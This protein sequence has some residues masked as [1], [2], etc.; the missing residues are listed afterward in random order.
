MIKNWTQKLLRY[1]QRKKEFYGT[2]WDLNYKLKKKPR[3]VSGI[4]NLGKWRIEYIDGYTLALMW[5]LQFLKK[6]NDFYTSKP[7]PY[8]LDCGSNIG[9]SVLRYKELYPECKITAFEPDPKIHNVLLNNIHHNSLQDVETLQAGL[10]SETGSQEFLSFK[11][12]DSQSGHINMDNPEDNQTISNRI[13]VDTVW[14]GDY[15]QTPIDFLKLDVEGAELIVLESCKHLLSNVKQMMV[16]VHYQVEQPE[17][18]IQL[19]SILKHSG[20]QIAIYQYFQSP[21]SSKPFQK[22]I[23]AVADQFPVL[24]AW[25]D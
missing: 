12:S 9:V 24:W 22:N 17:F 21:D 6:Y 11:N 10:W 20:F 14:L 19:M 13:H 4:V 7:N 18:L 16:E 5:E 15:L 25:R 23:N 3:S 8:I 2:L 1:S